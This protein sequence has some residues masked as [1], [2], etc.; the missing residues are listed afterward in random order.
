MAEL[1]KI[2][3]VGPVYPYKGGISH[4]TGLLVK[5][6][7]KTYDV[8][9]FSYSLQY[10]KFM[11]KKEQ[12]DYGNRTFAVAGAEFVINTANPMN[13]GL[14]GQTILSGRPDLVIVQW[15]HPYFAPC[16][17][18]M[19][20]KL[21]GVP[22]Y[23]VCHN[24]LPHERFPLDKLLTKATLKKG[25]FCILHSKLDAEDLKKMLPHMPYVRTVLPTYNAF[26]L[27][28]MGRAEARSRLGI[29]EQTK[30]ILFF[31][32]VRE[33]KGLRYLI[34]AAPLI[35]SGVDDAKIFVVGDFAGKRPEY[36]AMMQKSGAQDI[37]EVRD[38]YVPDAEIEPYFAAADVCVC[39]YI[40][41]TQSA[42]VQI[43]FGFGLPVIATDVGGLPEVVTD[44]VTGS[45]VPPQNASAL[46]AKI[47]AYFRD[48]KQEQYRKNVEA[49]EERFSWHHTADLIAEQFH[50]GTNG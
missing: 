7:K 13:W 46:A 43:A 8:Q 20:S 6:L 23:F 1:K 10:P 50:K 28:G 30:M 32:L 11:F 21:K 22:I 5:E 17:Q 24:I 26:K 12:K 27:T 16:Y 42:I 31:G 44:G 38:G 48:G 36:D 47:N 41:A 15:W 14:A 45:I 33:Y 3:V 39:P 18:A 35:K 2:A 9:V 49:E 19:L 25:D 4:Y 40:S 34:E 37:F 29:K